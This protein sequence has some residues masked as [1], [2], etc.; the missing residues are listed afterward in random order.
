MGQ[1]RGEVAL[2]KADRSC[3]L[4]D[5]HPRWD[6]KVR[7]PDPSSNDL[8]KTLWGGSK[9]PD[10]IAESF[11]KDLLSLCKNL[12]IACLRSSVKTSLFNF[13]SPRSI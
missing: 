12:P 2:Q 1:V 5:I 11:S 7:L 8:I 3:W 6:N 9:G 13:L 4:W 10:D